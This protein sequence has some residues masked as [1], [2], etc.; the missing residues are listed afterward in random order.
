LTTAPWRPEGG[1]P[2]GVFIQDASCFL[3]IGCRAGQEGMTVPDRVVASCLI[4]R[5][6]CGGPVVQGQ[7]WRAVG[8]TCKPEE[9]ASTACWP[10]GR[11][12]CVLVA[13]PGKS[14]IRYAF[15][16]TKRARLALRTAWESSLNRI[17]Y[18]RV[19]T[20]GHAADVQ[21]PGAIVA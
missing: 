16:A 13:T 14:T 18:C 21:V 3:D 17:D 10:R 5:N 20:T 9:E 6:W 4:L 7:P 2:R 12:K 11:S 19:S 15:R 1:V 8:L